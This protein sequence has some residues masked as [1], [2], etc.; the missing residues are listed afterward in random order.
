MGCEVASSIWASTSVFLVDLDG[1]VWTGEASA[2]PGAAAFFARCR[3]ASKQVVV[4]TNNSTRSRA[5]VAGRLASLVGAEVPERDIWTSASAAATILRDR[6]VK[7]CFAVGLRGLVH[8]LETAGIRVARAPCGASSAAESGVDARD[9]V[10]GVLEGIE[11]DGSVTAVVVGLDTRFSYCT[12]ATA[13]AYLRQPCAKG[14]P[15]LFVAT[16]LDAGDVHG[17]RFAPGGGCMV[18]AVALAAGRQPDVVAGKPSGDLARAVLQGSCNGEDLGAI[19]ML[20]DRLDTD[21]ALARRAGV[22]AVLVG[23]GV[24]GPADA[25]RALARGEVDAF[26]PAGLADLAA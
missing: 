18:A 23:T 4:V 10:D 17:A 8:E 25:E 15:R 12:L 2:V 3:S 16:N 19:T 9:D 22:R 1:V 6:G 14:T 20:G 11:L 21:M 5:A 7:A 24:E 26:L 13:A